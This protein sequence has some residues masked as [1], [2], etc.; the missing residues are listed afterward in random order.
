GAV[1]RVEHAELEMLHVRREHEPEGEERGERNGDE[2]RH[3]ERVAERRP[4]LAQEERPEPPPA[5]LRSA[6]AR[7]TRRNTS[8]IAGCSTGTCT[9]WSAAGGA[10]SRA[11]RSSA[12]TSTVSATPVGDGST[13]RSSAA[14]A[15]AADTPSTRIRYPPAQRRRSPSGVSSAIN[16]P[17]WMKHTRSQ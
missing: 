11:S 17:A 10:A 2:D 5:H 1:A 6:D 15:R 16:R 12:G 13:A 8:V 9:R 3:C 4:D 7:R 14:A